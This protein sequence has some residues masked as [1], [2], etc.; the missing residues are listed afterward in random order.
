MLPRRRFGGRPPVARVILLPNQPPAFAVGAVEDFKPVASQSS[1]L[2]GLAARY[3]IALYDL[4]DQAGSLDQVA[5]DLR[6]V[7]ELLAQ[8]SDLRRVVFS[9]LLGRAEQTRAVTAVLERAGAADLTRRFVGVVASNRR[10]FA[11][12]QVIEAYLAH[13]AEKRGEVVAEVVSAKPLSE[14]QRGRVGDALRRALGAQV[15]M[16]LKVDAGLIGGLIV[17]V[18]SKLVDHSLRTKL[19]R[20][21]LAM[22]GVG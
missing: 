17:R 4:A 12:P 13:L 9:P 6:G 18:G 2:S 20:L 1:G 11:L 3:A 14:A 8:S 19:V 15:V 7:R 10:L 5:Q 16:D 21:Q 22:R